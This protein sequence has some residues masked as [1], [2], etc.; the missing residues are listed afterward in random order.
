MPAER[1]VRRATAHGIVCAMRSQDLEMRLEPDRRPGAG[2]VRP[3][4]PGADDARRR[5][6]HLRSGNLLRSCAIYRGVH[7]GGIHRLRILAEWGEAA[8]RRFHAEVRQVAAVPQIMADVAHRGRK[9]RKVIW[10][11]LAIIEVERVLAREKLAEK[12]A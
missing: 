7:P 5:E 2:Q 11:E 8:L 10:L 9:R 12:A 4:M 6:C 1:G 3:I